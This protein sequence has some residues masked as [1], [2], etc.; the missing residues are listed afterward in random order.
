MNPVD[1]EVFLVYREY[2]ADAFPLGNSNKRG[3]SKIHPTIGVFS[4]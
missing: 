2:F 3:I 1:T 4:H